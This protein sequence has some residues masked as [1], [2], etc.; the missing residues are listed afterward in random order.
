[1]KHFL[2]AAVFSAAVLPF[3]LAMGAVSTSPAY[4]SETVEHS[5]RTD[6]N[7]CHKDNIHG[8]RHCH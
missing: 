4:E 6:R 1:M 3:G 5:G 8:G 2:F 7:G